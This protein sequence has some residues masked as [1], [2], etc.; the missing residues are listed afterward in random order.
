MNVKK[1]TKPSDASSPVTDAGG[2]IDGARM[3]GITGKGLPLWMD[4]C[5][6][7]YPVLTKHG[8]PATAL[9]PHGS[10]QDFLSRLGRHFECVPER[11]DFFPNKP[12]RTRLAKKKLKE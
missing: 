2:L 7:I 12:G 11:A 5:W 3:A 8:Y 4:L 9:L 6:A 1:M 10:I